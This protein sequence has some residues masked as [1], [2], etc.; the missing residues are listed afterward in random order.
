MSVALA[1]FSKETNQLAP[2]LVLP[3]ALH[4]VIHLGGLTPHATGRNEWLKT[5][6]LL[7][8]LITEGGCNNRLSVKHLLSRDLVQIGIRNLRCHELGERALWL[9]WLLRW[10]I[11]L[12]PEVVSVGSNLGSC[13]HEVD[14][15]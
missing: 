4:Q 10:Q 11:E 1:L 5:T 13:L 14:L 12:D 6:L 15:G 2:L 7:L 3:L 9:I 8:L